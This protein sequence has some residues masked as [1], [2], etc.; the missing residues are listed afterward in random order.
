MVGE[1]RAGVKVGREKFSGL[2]IRLGVGIVEAMVI[3]TQTVEGVLDM[4]FP[5]YKMPDV[6]APKCWTC[7]R[8]IPKIRLDALPETTE[9]VRCSYEKRQTVHDVDVDGPSTEDMNK[10]V[11][12]AQE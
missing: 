4:S 3:D 9:C 10:T 12:N 8:P 6:M 7:G 11:Q 1:D 5:I 2:R